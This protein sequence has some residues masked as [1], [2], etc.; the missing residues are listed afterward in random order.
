MR[1]API[2]FSTGCFVK[3]VEN[4]NNTLYEIIN[5]NYK[6]TMGDKEPMYTVHAYVPGLRV[7]MVKVF[8]QSELE[9]ATEEEVF[10]HKLRK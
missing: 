4:L 6:P 2:L 1:P 10:L 8:F 7:P 9:L 3:S 5:M